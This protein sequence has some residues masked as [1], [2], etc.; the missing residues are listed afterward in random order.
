LLR[1]MMHDSHELK[2][3]DVKMVLDELYREGLAIDAEQP[4]EQ[5]AA[6]KEAY[7]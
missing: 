5:I 4:Q 2:G 6:L 1:G 7:R 3:L